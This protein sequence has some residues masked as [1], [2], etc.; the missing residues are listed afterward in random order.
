MLLF[1]PE[2]THLLNCTWT[3]EAPSNNFHIQVDIINLEVEEICD[4]LSVSNKL[5]HFSIS[6]KLVK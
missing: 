3:I 1:A 5:L 2:L 4:Y 6:I